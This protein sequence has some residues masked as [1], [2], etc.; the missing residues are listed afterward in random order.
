M[1]VMGCCGDICADVGS[2]KAEAT[3]KCEKVIFKRAE[4]TLTCAEMVRWSA[5]VPLYGAKR[6]TIIS[7]E[8][9]PHN[10]GTPMA[11]D[12]IAM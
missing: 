8:Y 4:A 11:Y 6:G 1:A 9:I 10:I 12:I 7:R 3:P 5:E 2:K